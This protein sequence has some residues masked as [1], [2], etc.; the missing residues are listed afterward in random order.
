MQTA[1]YDSQNAL[2]LRGLGDGSGMDGAFPK[3]E[4]LETTVSVEDA[5]VERVE[6]EGERAEDMR[7]AASKSLAF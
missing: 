3:S 4:V 2:L 5:A 6:L 1:A 7:G